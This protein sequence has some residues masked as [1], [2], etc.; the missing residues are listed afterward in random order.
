MAR[1]ATFDDWIDLFHQWQKDINVDTRQLGDFTFEPKF[2]EAEA[3]IEFGHFAGQP[4]WERVTQIPDQRI[5]DALL[6]YIVVQGD[7]EF[8]SV[9][10][11]R[12]LFAT[13][14]S[15]YDRRGLARIMA[16]E[17]RHGWQMA[18]LLVTYFG[19]A[20]KLEAE[21]LLQRRAFNRSR[22][23]GSF[24]EDISNWLDMIVFTQFIDRD[25]KY[26]LKML[27]HSGFKPLAQSMGPMLRE[28]AFHLGTGQT[29][30]KRIL[31]AGKVPIPLLQKYFNK[32]VS[33]AY[34]LFG[35][36]HSSSAQWAYEWGLKGRYNEGPAAGTA[37][38]ER[39]NEEARALYTGEITKLTN[40]LNR[41]IPDDQPKLFIPDQK[42]N[43]K[44]GDYAR[45][46]F[47]VHG[48]PLPAESFADYRR[49]NL[50]S[51]EDRQRV[52][53]LLKVNDWIAPRGEVA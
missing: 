23:L 25:G 31:R 2:G 19:S 4:K 3:E 45:Q 42:F 32:W 44:I 9:E 15:E 51:D 50:P 27:Q 33:T 30:L 26:Q 28:E 13:A 7:T 41:L 34:D 18:Y 10:Q 46:P 53:D 6:N 1:I 39:L 17:T 49:Q 16:E 24:N 48:N 52:A 35:T 8:A 37:N 21:K 22:L 47:D 40:D 36:D 20:G 43:R 12:Y 14:P 5:R 38:R 29:G 11:Q